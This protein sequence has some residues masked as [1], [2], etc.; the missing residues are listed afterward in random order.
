MFC[1]IKLRYSKRNLVVRTSWIKG[2][3]PA[4]VYNQGVKIGAK[5][6]VYYSNNENEEPN[7]DGN[8]SRQFQ[9][10]SVALY[11]ANLY[12][13]FGKSGIYY[14]LMSFGADFF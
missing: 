1:G 6:T 4:K 8:I 14:Y 5:Y 7:F 10:Q 13:F 9:P 11:E 12:S 3:S 2:F